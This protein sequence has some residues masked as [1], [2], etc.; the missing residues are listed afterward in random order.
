MNPE[1]AI[2]L[3]REALRACFFV[4]GPILAV[5][6]LIGLTVGVL[7]AMTQV[8]DQTVSF[9]PKILLMLVAIALALPWLS[10]QM[11]DY[12]KDALSH[13]VISVSGEASF[14]LQ[15]ESQPTGSWML[16]SESPV[17]PDD[18]TAIRDEMPTMKTN[19]GTASSMPR[20]R[21]GQRMP[22]LR[23]HRDSESNEGQDAPAPRVASKEDIGPF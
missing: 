5:G 16:P 18:Q 15:E 1:D 6:L 21:S 2:D 20:L 10:E 9:V 11:I 7:Q 23:W 12:T 17:A 8:Q 13:P 3:G 14:T 19:Q 4:G 22:N